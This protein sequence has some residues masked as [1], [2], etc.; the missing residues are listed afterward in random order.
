MT[1][2][3]DRDVSLEQQ[4]LV[5][6]DKTRGDRRKEARGRLDNKRGEAGGSSR[7]GT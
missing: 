4:E 3:K 1:R 5:M 7:S 6:L 2:D